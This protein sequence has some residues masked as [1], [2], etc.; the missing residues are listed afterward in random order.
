[1]NSVPGPWTTEQLAELLG[2]FES[3]LREAG[4]AESSISTYVDRSRY[5]VRWLNREYTPSGGRGS[6]VG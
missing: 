4:L 3:E 6:S 5:F 1:M 2:V